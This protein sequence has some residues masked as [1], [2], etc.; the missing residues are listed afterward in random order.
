MA[1]PLYFC[2]KQMVLKEHPGMSSTDVSTD[3]SGK[4]CGLKQVLNTD[5]LQK[6]LLLDFF[7]FHDAFA[8]KVNHHCCRLSLQH[9]KSTV[10]VSS[11]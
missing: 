3:P 2:L 9:P 6:N 4:D 1:T 7:K 8:A 10:M 5:K 11:R